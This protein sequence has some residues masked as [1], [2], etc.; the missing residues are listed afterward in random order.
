MC[1]LTSLCPGPFP[2]PHAVA[3]GPPSPQI[4]YSLV[5]LIA[6]GE[7]LGARPIILHLLDIP[8]T[9]TKLAGVVMELEDMASPLLIGSGPGRARASGS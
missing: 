2:C 9:E 1:P 8:G 4:A 5:F 6:Q 3:L 7:M